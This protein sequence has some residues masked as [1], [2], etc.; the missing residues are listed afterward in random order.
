MAANLRREAQVGMPQDGVRRHQR[1]FDA[2]AA[3]HV[4][5]VLTALSDHGSRSYF[6]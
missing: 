6:G 2:V 3:G 5:E 4:E 1:L